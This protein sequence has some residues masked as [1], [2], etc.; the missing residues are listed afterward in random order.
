ML[1]SLSQDLD[2]CWY[3]LCCGCSS[4]SFFGTAPIKKKLTTAIA[5]AVTTAIALAVT[6]AGAI[7]SK[8]QFNIIQFNLLT[9]RLNSARPIK[10][11][12]TDIPQSPP[13]TTAKHVTQWS[14]IKFYRKI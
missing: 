2:C 7:A 9:W 3:S 5:L 10:I 4:D 11:P 14:Q 13:S 6:T 1:N 8:I 12:T